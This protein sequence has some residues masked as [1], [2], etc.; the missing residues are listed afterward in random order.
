M[1]ELYLLIGFMIF[2][3]IIAIEIRSILSSVVTVGIVGFALCIVFLFLRAPDVA[4]TQ[5]IVEVIALVVLVR[6]TGVQQDDTERRS[7]LQE[8]FSFVTIIAFIVL[9]GGFSFY[10]L[11]S[12]PVFGSPLMTVSKIY[13]VEGLAK[14]GAANLV[15]SVLL[16]FRAYDTLG[17]ATILFTAILGGIAVMR[18]VG[19]KKIDERDDLDS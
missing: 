5:L 8:V 1:F 15:T 12:L 7:N 3:A 18:K 13:L 11:Q 9:F 4:I 10:A 17:E 6:A 19:R 2:G 14:T 16:D